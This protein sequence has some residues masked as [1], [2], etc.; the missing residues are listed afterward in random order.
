M[1][2]QTSRDTGV[3]VVDL[4]CI[5]LRLLAHG[6]CVDAGGVLHPAAADHLSAASSIVPDVSSKSKGLSATASALV[7]WWLPIPIYYFARPVCLKRPLLT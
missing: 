7:S 6:V 1:K 3:S 4:H 5:L 2:T